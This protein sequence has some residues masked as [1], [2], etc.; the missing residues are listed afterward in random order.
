LLWSSGAPVPRQQRAEA[1]L[2]NV[3]D[4][5]EDIGEPSLRIDVIQLGGL[6]QRV[7]ERGAIRSA[8]GAGEQPRFSAESNAPFILPM[9]GKWRK[10]ITNGIRILAVK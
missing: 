5:G 4:A 10:F 8:L 2:R 1:R 9:S 3:G 6:Y 7:H